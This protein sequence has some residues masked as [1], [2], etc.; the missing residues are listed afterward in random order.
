MS[1]AGR[2]QDIRSLPRRN[3]RRHPPTPTLTHTYTSTPTTAQAYKKKDYQTALQHYTA[4][5]K[6][7]HSNIAALNNRAVTYLAL[8][9]HTEAAADTAAVLA[10]QPDNV[11]ALLRHA[12][13]CE[14]LGRGQEATAD[15][16]K[17]LQ[18]EPQNAEAKQR[19][20]RLAGAGEEGQ[21]QQEVGEYPPPPRDGQ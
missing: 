20:G 15:C 11:K 13:A 14:A 10:A 17:V 12:A 18:L 9:M 1:V 5:I 6:L 21:Q 16:K 19:L 2:E 4:A 7:D 8:N 3:T